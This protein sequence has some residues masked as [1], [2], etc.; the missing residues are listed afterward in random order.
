MASEYFLGLGI[1]QRILLRVENMTGNI[2]KE[3][4]ETTSTLYGVTIIVVHCTLTM[5]VSPPLPAHNEEI[6]R[7][8]KR[9]KRRHYEE[10]REMCSTR[11]FNQ[12]PKGT[13]VV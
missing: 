7:G 3:Q 11:C 10:G 4:K 1:G 13:M 2:K 9:C 5:L 6:K 12:M 8:G